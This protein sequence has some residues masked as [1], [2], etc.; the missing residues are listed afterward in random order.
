MKKEPQRVAMRTIAI[1]IP[2]MAP[3]PIP[4][5][6]LFL[7]LTMVVWLEVGFATVI[8]VVVACD[9]ATIL[10]GTDVS[11]VACEIEKLEFS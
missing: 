7:V 3:V 8:P 11:N 6:S 5:E 1:A 9:M 2:A 10:L 4:W